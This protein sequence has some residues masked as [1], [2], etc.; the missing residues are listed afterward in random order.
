MSG[1][2]MKT[3]GP[4]GL[5]QGWSR[6]LFRLTQGLA[7]VGGALFVAMVGL[8][9]VSI[10]GRKLWSTPVNGDL[11]LL[12]MGTGMA[13]AAFFPYCTMMGEHLRVE[14]FT[15]RWPQR[16]LALLDGLAH[17]LLAVAMA[18][19]AWRTTLQAGELKEAGEVTVMRNIPVWIPEACLVP[20]LALTAL[21]ALNRAIH[22]LC[23][24]RRAA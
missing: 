7:L 17:V 4:D 2:V 22:L 12:Q 3:A 15:A 8:S 5:D 1:H 6:P 10:V 13:A 23:T 9:V 14:F 16:T 11:E 21:S 19:L 24:E 18:L 20:S